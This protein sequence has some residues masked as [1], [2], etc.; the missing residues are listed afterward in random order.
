MILFKKVRWKNFLSY[1]NV[2]T[3]INLTNN[4]MTL[5]VGENGSGK[6]TMMDA[7]CFA[8]FGKPFRKIN[9]PTLVNSVNQKN[10]LVELEF[11]TNGQFYKVV[12]GLKPAVFTIHVNGTLLN[13]DAATKDYQEVLEKQILRTTFKSFTQIVILGSATFTPFM[14]L[15]AQDRRLVLDDLLDIQVFSVMHILARQKMS[16][17]K[18]QLQTLSIQV[19]SERDKEKLLIKQINDL[20]KNSSDIEKQ[21]IEDIQKN[22]EQKNKILTDIN[23]LEE[24]SKSLESYLADDTKI[25]TLANDLVPLHTK[26]KSKID[27]L[28]KE[29][30]FF[31][32]NDV[33]S[34]C[35]Q[36][37]EE[38]FKTEQVGKN[39]DELSKLYDG[40]KDIISKVTDIREKISKFDE[41]KKQLSECYTNI[42]VFRGKVESIDSYVKIKQSELE[43]LAN[44]GEDSLLA[45]NLQYLQTAREK[46]TKLDNQLKNSNTERENLEIVLELLKD[47]GIKSQIIGK[48][49][50]IINQTINKYLANMDFM[51]NFILD[52][53]FKETIKSRYR[54]EFSYENFS[55]G[56]KARIDLS[57]LLTWRLI[58]K[59]RNSVNTNLLILDEVFDGSLDSGGSDELVNILKEVV[60]GCNIFVISHRESMR[61]QFDR[62]IKVRKEKN[63]SIMEGV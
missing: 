42:K 60:K 33:C 46:L 61:E 37:I 1:G 19:A 23:S 36:T 2:W 6:S 41:T 17:L 50:P 13:K 12:R 26:I 21:I 40:L 38:H 29:N 32:E 55:E 14:K 49:L 58:A 30:H 20:K 56:E 10:C 4:H 57:L 34:V 52:E 62:I 31:D 28:E 27:R 54:D 35:H 53:N 22:N 18:S 25:R 3:E 51:V 43:S 8:L 16:E 59:M 63:Y 48:Y 15:T 39:K 7:I 44:T 5:I 45:K 47:G 24:K 11:E 9:K